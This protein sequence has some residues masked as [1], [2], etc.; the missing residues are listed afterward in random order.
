MFLTGPLALV[1]LI[2]IPL[3]LSIG[4]SDIKLEKQVKSK[5]VLFH[6]QKRLLF[7][8]LSL[9]VVLFFDFVKWL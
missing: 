2:I 3:I 1:M 8:L 6:D 7:I 9:I 5:E 4:L